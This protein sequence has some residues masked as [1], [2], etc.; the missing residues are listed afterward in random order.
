M[1]D[2]TMHSAISSS[3]PAFLAKLWAMVNEESTD[4][5]IGW[6]EDQK[7]FYIRNQSV[8]SMELLPVYY[9]HNNMASFVRQLNMYGFRKVL[10]PTAG[11]LRNESDEMIFAHSDFV[12]DEPWGLDN[13]KRKIP[14]HKDGKLA[15]NSTELL[16]RL[17]G[18][19]KTMKGKQ[20]SLDS[21]LNKMKRENESL[22]REVL[23]LRQKHAKQQQIVNKL[24]Q[25]LVSF[26]QPGRGSAGMGLKRKQLP[27][28]ED[29]LQGEPSAKTPRLSRTFS[30]DDSSAHLDSRRST[31]NSPGGPVIHEV[32][33]QVF[34]PSDDVVVASSQ[35]PM[36]FMAS[37]ER[38]S[39]VDWSP[40][41]EQLAASPG[42][43]KVAD[44]AALQQQQ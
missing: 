6:T 24:I 22:W 41:A 17:Y 26:V 11:S 39:T 20:D 35:L 15:T 1:Q 34:S 33:D 9:K 2:K 3:V 44:P 28:L 18:E 38:P 21:H 29:T 23:V 43:S 13:I 36:D 32:T 27:M 31:A 25:F 8:F 10:S 4:S 12:K 30:L 16:S 19:V 42:P 14:L 5:V 37:P 7:S 40:V